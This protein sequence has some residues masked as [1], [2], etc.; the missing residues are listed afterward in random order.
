MKTTDKTLSSTRIDRIREQG[1]QCHT[2]AQI[3]DLA[4][5]NK[6]NRWVDSRLANRESD[7]KPVRVIEFGSEAYF[8]LAEKLA[9]Q[10]RQGSIAFDTDVLL[11]IDGD[12]V[13]VKTV[14]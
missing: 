13:L 11:W 6:N 12:A 10:G 4:F 8:K 1:Y 7:V 2:D 9:H 5:F 3:N 14:R